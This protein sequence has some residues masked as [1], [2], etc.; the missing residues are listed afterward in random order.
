[1][2]THTHSL[3]MA[4]G[5]ESRGVYDRIAGWTLV[6]DLQ[7][8]ETKTTLIYNTQEYKYTNKTSEQ[9]CATYFLD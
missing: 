8:Q 1:M 5:M 6:N 9:S 3:A 4:R 7:T 2:N